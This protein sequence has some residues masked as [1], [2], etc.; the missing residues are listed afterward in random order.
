MASTTTAG[1]RVEV[2]VSREVGRS[3]WSVAS[4]NRARTRR[5]WLGRQDVTSHRGGARGRRT[6]GNAA[7]KRTRG[8]RGGSVWAGTPRFMASNHHEDVVK[9]TRWDFHHDDAVL[10]RLRH[11]TAHGV[12]ATS[13]S[14]PFARF[15]GLGFDA[16]HFLLDTLEGG[17]NTANAIL[18]CLWDH[19]MIEV[20]DLCLMLVCNRPG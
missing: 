9:F 5:R 7:G 8:R 13:F 19:L 12:A 15:L 17:S 14:S 6:G 18:D 3:D 11:G 2:E 4:L 1:K 10:V 16:G 20:D